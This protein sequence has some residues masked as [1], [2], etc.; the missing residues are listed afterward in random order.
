MSDSLHIGRATLGLI[1]DDITDIDIDCFV[2][3]ARH[4]LALGSGFGGGIAV[5]GGPSVQEELNGRGPLKTTEVVVTGAGDLKASSIIHAVGPRFQEENLGE[6]LSRTV[7]NCL[8]AADERGLSRIAFPPMGTGFYCVPLDVSAC[9]MLTTI[10]DYLNGETNI[11]EVIICL[12]DKREY[13]PFQKQL[14][15][16]AGTVKEAV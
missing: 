16:M 12:L 4:D 2:Y 8:K 7:I 3:Y 5:R 14:A 10:R 11:R 6:K 1:K 15:D 13:L 9:V